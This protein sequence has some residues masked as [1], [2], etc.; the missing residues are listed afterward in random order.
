VILICVTS[1]TTG[2]REIQWVMKD[3]RATELVVT[4][5]CIANLYESIRIAENRMKPVQ[6]RKPTE[7]G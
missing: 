3:S 5:R 2:R 4:V 1:T 7:S 6:S